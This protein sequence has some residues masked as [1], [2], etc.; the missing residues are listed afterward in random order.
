MKDHEISETLM[1][2]QDWKPFY[3]YSTTIKKPRH[4]AVLEPETSE[5][6]NNLFFIYQYSQL[7]QMLSVVYSQEPMVSTEKGGPIDFSKVPLEAREKRQ[8]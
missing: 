5:I 4:E 7:K 1:A 6:L 3:L 2:T 8:S